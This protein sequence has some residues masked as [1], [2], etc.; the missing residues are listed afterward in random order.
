MLL[1]KNMLKFQL[2]MLQDEFISANDQADVW[3]LKTDFHP[4]LSLPS[5]SGN[6]ETGRFREEGWC[7]D[8]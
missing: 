7:G 4:E 5:L 8:T 2:L 6:L 3:S 1:N